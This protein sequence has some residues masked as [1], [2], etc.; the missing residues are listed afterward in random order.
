[1]EIL[2]DE[3]YKQNLHVN[4]YVERKVQLDEQSYE[5]NGITRS[6]KTTL[7]KKYLLTCKKSTYIYIDCRD[8]RIDSNTMNGVLTRYCNQNGIEIVVLDN[9]NEHFNLPNVKQLLITTEKPLNNPYLPSIKLSTL[10]YEEF[11]A[12]EPKYDSTA[13]NHF[14]QLGGLPAM[15]TINSEERHL[16]I[17]QALMRSLSQVEF[18][19]V[20]FIAKSNSLKLSTFSMYEK[21]RSERKISKDMLYRS[22]DSLLKR[23]YLFQVPKYK[24]LRAV[25]KIYLCDIAFKNAL[26]HQKN[27]RLL[28]ENL[29]YL[30]L[31]KRKREIFYDDNID[32]YVPSQNRIILCMPFS[33]EDVL[34]KTVEKIEEFIITHGVTDVKVVTMSSEAQLHHPFVNVEMLPFSEWAIIEG[35]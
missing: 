16:Y 22:V 3:Y 25:K 29:I 18:E 28:F 17:Q 35:E 21:L 6:G 4:N 10:D 15:H 5:I 9:Y 34:F 11:L 23:D 20:S 31:H 13:L 12:Y 27:F 30:E 33:N 26:T 2:L 7:V 24:H 14:L 8:I 19:I 32:F 1:M